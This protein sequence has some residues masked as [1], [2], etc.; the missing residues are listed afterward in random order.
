[1]EKVNV[2][3]LRIGNII[4]GVYQL[5]ESNDMHCSICKFLGYHPFDNYIYVESKDG[6]EEFIQFQPIPLSEEILLKC[7]SLDRDRHKEKL[8]RSSLEHDIMEERF[9][10][11]ATNGCEYILE[12]E[13]DWLFI[14]IKNSKAINYFVW[15]IK[16]LHQLQNIY[17]SLCGQELNTAGLI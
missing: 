2:S 10:F 4:N 13:E 1:M 6:T 17:F 11:C 9:I 16:Y 12:K 8:F 14:G 3:E 15:D 5:E 7:L